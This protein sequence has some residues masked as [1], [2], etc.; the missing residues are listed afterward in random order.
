[1][2]ME[3]IVYLLGAGFSAPLG[4]PVVR[5]FLELSKDLYFREEDTYEHFEKVFDTI[6]DLSVCKNYYTTDLYNIEE[7]LSLLEMSSSLVGDE[8]TRQS[9]IQYISDV[10]RHYTPSNGGRTRGQHWARTVFGPEPWNYYALFVATILNFPVRRMTEPVNSTEYLPMDPIPRAIEYSVITLNY[11][12]V[13]ES[14]AGD[15]NDWVVKEDAVLAKSHPYRHFDRDHKQY[16]SPGGRFNGYLC[17]LHGSIDTGDIIPPTWNK[18]LAQGTLLKA[19]EIAHFLLQHANHVRIIGY[20][21]PEA[22]S[23]I[24]YL[25]RAASLN[26]LHLKTFDVL[27]LDRDETVRKRYDAFVCFPNYR[28]KSGCVKNYLEQHVNYYG[29]WPFTV[30]LGGL[31]EVHQGFFSG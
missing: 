17:K 19:W 5:N 14:L 15:L 9:F 23:Y 22:D 31:E 28:F 20:S 4:L 24:K 21:L 11:D 8:E 13:L 25:L 3:R 27:C 1:M 7:I 6:R 12:L 18:R 26:N 2:T 10:I 16:P 29:G 30:D